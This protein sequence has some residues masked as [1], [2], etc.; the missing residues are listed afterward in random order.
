[1][2]HAG[3]YELTDSGRGPRVKTGENGDGPGW[4]DEDVV[5]NV[6]LGS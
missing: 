5:E 2:A 1:V 6:P 3:T 4:S